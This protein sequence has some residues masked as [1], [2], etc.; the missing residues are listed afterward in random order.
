MDV[1]LANRSLPQCLQSSFPAVTSGMCPVFLA[2]QIAPLHF[3]CWTGCNI[4]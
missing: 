1:G 2:S 3:S 4:S